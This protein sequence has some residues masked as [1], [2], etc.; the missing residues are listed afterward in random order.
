MFSIIAFALADMAAKIEMVRLLTWKACWLI[1]QDRD[2]T[3]AS[4]M[5]KL[6]GSKMVQKVTTQTAEI[7]G[8]SS[9]LANSYADK[10]VRDARVFTSIEGTDNIQKA[11]IAS[12]L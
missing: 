8:A 5:A 7:L 10:Y 2:Y 12:L 1:D 3:T 4:S 6:V 11:I 9:Y